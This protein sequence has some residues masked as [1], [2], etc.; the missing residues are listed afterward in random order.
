MSLTA[1]REE[2]CAANQALAK[3][4]L[5]TLSFGNVSGVDR[6]ADALVI[7]PS[8]VGYDRLRPED[9]VVVS[10]S[11]ERVVEGSLRPSSD[12]PA[13]AVLYRRFPSIG[14]VVH[15]HSPFASAWAQ[16][17]RSIPCL[18]TTHADH[19]PG[20]VPVTRRLSPEEIGGQY[21]R[22]TG[23][24]VAETLATLGVKPLEMPAALVASHGPFTWG[25]D[26]AD[27][28][29]N[30]IALEAVA[31][32]AYRTFALSAAVEAIDDA[33]LRRHFDRKHGSGAYYGQADD[34]H[35]S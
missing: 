17:H 20:P 28:V 1:L 16:A 12:T 2:V 31:A 23:K 35:G 26:P 7:K 8:G 24:V 21:E 5:V 34:V 4:G 33:L 14:G 27:A 15:T 3:A 9:M 19:F 6:E 18:G 10:L 25:R 29:T 22:E 32:M 11:D 30:A 13:H